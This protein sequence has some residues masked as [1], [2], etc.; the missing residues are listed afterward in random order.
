[1]RSSEVVR[2]GEDFYIRTFGAGRNRWGDYSD[3]AVDPTN[4]K[5]F[6]VFNE[7]ADQQGTILTGL[8]GEDG[9]LRMTW[10]RYRP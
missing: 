10:A 9:R 2:A 5:F 3:I 6:W 8:P 7:F 1:M 4:N